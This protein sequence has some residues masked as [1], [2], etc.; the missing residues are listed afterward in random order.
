VL[1][2]F[3]SGSFE[4]GKWSSAASAH[5]SGAKRNPRTDRNRHTGAGGPGFGFGGPD[6][7]HLPE[8]STQ[9]RALIAA[10][11]LPPVVTPVTSSVVSRIP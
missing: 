8:A 6:H 3:M 5:S 2:G 4:E 1:A 9:N 10:S 11:P 7:Q